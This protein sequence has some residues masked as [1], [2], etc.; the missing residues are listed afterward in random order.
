MVPPLAR[1]SPMRLWPH[2]AAVAWLNIRILFGSVAAH[3]TRLGSAG[4]AF[5]L[6]CLLAAVF[7]LGRVVWTWRAA[8]RAE[9]LLCAAIILNIGL[10]L[11]SV[12]PLPVG[13]RELAAVLPCGAVLAARACVPARITGTVPAGLAVAVTALAALVPLAAPATQPP[14]TPDTL[15]LAAW[16]EAHGLSYGIAG[17]W[18]ASVVTLQSG[19]RVQIRAVDLRTN[20]LVP[21]WETNFLWYNAY[22]HDA[23]FVVTDY[24]GRYPAAA[25]ERHFG[26]PVAAHRVASWLVLIYRTNLLWQLGH[27]PNQP[28]PNQ[29]PQ[30]VH[31]QSIVLRTPDGR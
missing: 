20:I 6:V 10:Y 12:M 17:Y 24:D 15:P 3:D 11:I 25:F 13:T 2:H 18:D 14:L 16:L 23:R 5:G 27:Y 7:G 19:G 31:G 1:L 26:T 28:D 22:R 9:Q 8:S 29:R 30:P 4:A 21:S